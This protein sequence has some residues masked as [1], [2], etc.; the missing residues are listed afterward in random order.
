MDTIRNIFRLIGKDFLL[1]SV[2]NFNLTTLGHKVTKK[3]IMVI[4]IYSMCPRKTTVRVFIYEE[5]VKEV[6]YSHQHQS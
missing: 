4:L 3:R 6:G 2:P 1:K 5:C